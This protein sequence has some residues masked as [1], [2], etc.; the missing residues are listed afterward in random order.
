MRRCAPACRASDLFGFEG[1]VPVP[2]KLLDRPRRTLA[3]CN[4]ASQNPAC[5]GGKSELETAKAYAFRA[6]PDAFKGA[7]LIKWPIPSTVSTSLCSNLLAALICFLHVGKQL[8]QTQSSSVTLSP[9][10]SSAMP[11]SLEDLYFDL[12]SMTWI[13]KHQNPKKYFTSSDPHHGIQGICSDI[14]FPAYRV[15]VWYSIWHS[16]FEKNLTLYLA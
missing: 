14:Y 12:T 3:I 2:L 13:G 6:L 11:V 16:I 10:S 15:T 7:G 4:N 5:H 9:S 8:C 1:F